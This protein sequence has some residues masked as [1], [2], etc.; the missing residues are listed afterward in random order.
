LNDNLGA[1]SSVATDR[2][3][4][5]SVRERDIDLLV[6]EELQVSPAFRSMM[7]GAVER[8]IP[9]AARIHEANHAVHI[10]LVEAGEGAGETDVQLTLDFPDLPRTILLIEN[11]IDAPL[12][13][14]QIAR[15]CQRA[16]KL[17]EQGT[18]AFVVLMAP[19][20]YGDVHGVDGVIEYEEILGYF[21]RR[22]EETDGELERR[23]RHKV[24]VVR[25]AIWRA[26]HG[27]T[28]VVNPVATA[29]WASYSR[30]ARDRSQRLL[31]APGD[32]PAGSTFISFR[33]ALAPIASLGAIPIIHKIAQGVV[34]IQ[35]PRAAL[36]VEVVR[37]LLPRPPGLLFEA[38]GRSLVV[39]ATVSPIDHLRPFEEIEGQVREG[40]DAVVRLMEWWDAGGG[41]S[42]ADVLGRP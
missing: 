17:R 9:L 5:S 25:G 40:L 11:K 13:P 35:I 31:V 21:I 30:L 15:Y 7:L 39:R 32:R 10:N 1:D 41:Q 23:I 14:S 8:L 36:Q 20:I 4:E 27:Y 3:A 26:E 38:A 24:S 19:H 34:D 16:A 6:R 33:G 29:F 37:R 22:A 28:P 2:V 18:P 12:Q 42:I